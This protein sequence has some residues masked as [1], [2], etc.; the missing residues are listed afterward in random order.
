MITPEELRGIEGYPLRRRRPV[1]EGNLG[2]E[3]MVESRAAR[4]GKIATC[5]RY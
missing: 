4:S 1:R 2:R 5:A 3:R